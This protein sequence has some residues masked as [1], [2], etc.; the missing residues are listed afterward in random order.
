[1]NQNFPVYTTESACQDCYK[2]VRHCHCKAIQIIDARAAILPKR[3]V[4]CGQC[5]RVCPSHAKKIR[6]DLGRAQRLIQSGVPV[7]ASIAPSFPGHYRG[8]SANRLAGALMRL[9]FA[10]VGETAIGAQLVSA[11]TA[12]LLAAAGPGAWLSSAC[13]SAVD[14]VRKYHPDWAVRI[15]PVTSPVQAH[16]RWLKQRF[17]SQ[18]KTVFFGPCAA[19]K[20]EADRAPEVLNLALTF[21]EL[22]AWLGEAGIELSE[23][24]EV[25]LAH[26]SAEEGRLYPVEGGMNETLRAPELDARLITVSGLPNLARLIEHLDVRALNAL[27]T[28]LFVEMLAC[29]GGCLNGPAMDPGGAGLDVILE[30]EKFGK[31][32]SSVGR[33]VEVAL[34]S[35]FSPEA[36]ASPAPDEAALR[37]A[38][39][40]LGKFSAADELNCG[41]CGYNSCRQLAAALVEGK[42][43][44]SM[45]LSHLRQ[46]SQKTSNALI[47]YIPVAVVLADEN[48]QVV[49]CNRHFAELCGEEVLSAYEACGNLSGAYLA[50]LLPFTDLF[51]S[52]LSGGGEIEKFNQPFGDRILNLSVFAIAEGKFIGAILQDVTQYEMK[53]EQVAGRAREVIRKN[54]LTVQKIAH[55]LGEHMADTEIL[56]N[57]IAGT[58]S[59]KP[60]EGS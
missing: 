7:H 48:L 17:G 53:R 33:A 21:G 3:C 13:P 23:V 6:S 27:G 56:L 40:S 38:L 58:W 46:I 43:E 51:E 25:P 22:D 32:Q 29:E 11:R 2:C 12:E 49:E 26:G 47:R 31:R 45:C 39:E 52:I 19:K 15:L 18:I 37:A 10:G 1:M 30:V 28:K 50:S 57:E 54:V 34:D 55:A 59:D 36:I 16:C 4:S 44:T 14:F 60:G 24:A 42:A 35:P 8:V 20:G 41:A 9:G 5:V